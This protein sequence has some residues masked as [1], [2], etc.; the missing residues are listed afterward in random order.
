MTSTHTAD[1][2]YSVTAAGKSTYAKRLVAQ[3]HATLFAI[4]PKEALHA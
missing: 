4:G 1:L 3:T 2:V